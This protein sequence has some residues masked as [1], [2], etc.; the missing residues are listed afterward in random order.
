MAKV[1]L[2]TGFLGAGKTTFIH[3]YLHHLRDRRVLI[4]E[5]EFGSIGVDAGFLKD[6]GCPIEDLSG[7]CM[8]CKGRDQFIAMLVRAADCDRILV[9]PSGIYDVDEFFSVM[10]EPAVKA[11]CEVGSVLAIVDARRPEFLSA[12]SGYLMTT[13]LLAAGTVILSKAQHETPEAIEETVAWL[14]ELI[15]AQGGDRVLSDDVCA[16]DWDALTDEDFIRL[17]NSG[18]RR[19]AHSR[20]AMNHGEIYDSFITAGRCEGEDD[21]RSRLRAL[22]ADARCGNVIRAKGYLRDHDK[23]YYEVNCT[24]RELSVKP[25]PQVRRGVLV[26]IGQ[27]LNEEALNG[28]FSAEGR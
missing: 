14:N 9:E 23:N 22:M 13:Q 6:E 4:I 10:E 12:E 27:N 11:C 18:F 17:Q 8:C 2:I 26:I 19:A 20:R 24:R 28:V 1:D 3:K 5:N 16:V 25:A 21:L 7:V 15:R